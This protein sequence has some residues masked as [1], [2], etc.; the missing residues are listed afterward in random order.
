MGGRMRYAWAGGIIFGSLALVLFF[1]VGGDNFI[2]ITAYGTIE[3]WCASGDERLY[4][5]KE[6]TWYADMKAKTV[7]RLHPTVRFDEVCPLAVPVYPK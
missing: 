5:Y 3:R 7:A 2:K 6:E 1:T 4:S